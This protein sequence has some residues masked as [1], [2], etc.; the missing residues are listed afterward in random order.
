MLHVQIGSRTY[1]ACAIDRLGRCCETSIPLHHSTHCCSLKATRSFRNFNESQHSE[2]TEASKSACC[3]LPFCIGAACCSMS[4]WKCRVKKFV[5]NL[6]FKFGS[7]SDS[8]DP[9]GRALAAVPCS[10][11]AGPGRRPGDAALTDARAAV[12]LRP[13][14]PPLAT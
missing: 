10:D 5:K 9:S 4:P 14:R 7:P 11:W 2:T 3:S 13:G 12:P 1:A 6:C 8:E